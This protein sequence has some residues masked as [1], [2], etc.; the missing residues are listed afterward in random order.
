MSAKQKIGIMGENIAIEY[1]QS[2]G[3]SIKTRNWRCP[4]GE[5]D[6]ICQQKSLWV[7]V[8]VKTRHTNDINDALI[9]FTMRK[10]T[11]TLSTIHYYLAHHHLEETSWRFDIIGIALTS[12]GTHLIQHVED[13]LEW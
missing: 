9:Q 8:E 2:H 7:F 5:L 6:I 12:Y 4:Y 13:A 3:Y 1:L 10:Q 11:R